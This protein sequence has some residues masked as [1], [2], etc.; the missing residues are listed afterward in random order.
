MESFEPVVSLRAA[1]NVGA[2]IRNKIE[3]GDLKPGDRLPSE[4]ELAAQFNVSRNTVREAIRSLETAGVI[5]LKKGATGGAFIREGSSMGVVASFS[6]LL[7]LRTISP[8]HLGEARAIVG[9]VAARLACER[10]S[11]EDMRRMEACV[12]EAVA[13]AEAGDMDRRSRANFQFH[14]ELARATKNPILE[15]LTDA[16]TSINKKFAERVGPPPNEEIIPSRK[17]LMR[18]L[19][20]RDAD[21][22]SREMEDHLVRLQTFYSARLGQEKG[23]RATRRRD[24]KSAKADS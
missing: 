21:G 6:D 14:L 3:T 23:G 8:E 15:I 22:A 11:E 4:R 16:I 9:S 5:Q 18:L 1:D 17:R 24:R 7:A 20:A 12:E 19:K 2:Q 13:G 10:A